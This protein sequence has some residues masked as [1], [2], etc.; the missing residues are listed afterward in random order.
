MSKRAVHS[1]LLMVVLV[2]VLSGS[3][4]GYYPLDDPALIGW[5]TCDEGEGSVVADSS[6]NGNDGTFVNGDPVWVEG[7]DGTAVELTIPTLIEIPVMD[8]TLEEATMAGWIKPYGTQP[9]WAS[10]MMHREGS[11]HGFNV[12][13]DYRLAYHWND[14]S[15]SWSYRGDAYVVDNEWTFA[16][17]TIEPDRATFYVNG[18]EASANVASHPAAT[19]DGNV[20]LGGD[21]TDGQSGRRMTGAL[22]D[23]SFFSRALTAEEIEAIMGG[24][25]DPALAALLSPENGATDVS[26]DVT[27]AWT[28]G[29]SAATHDV[30][31]GTSLEDVEAASRANPMDLLVSQGQTAAIYEA[32]RLDFG[33]TYYWR[34]DEVGS[35]GAVLAGSVW[36]FT[37]EPLSYP[38]RNVI[39]TTNGVSE[40]DAGPENTVNGSGLNAG[41]QHSTAT[42]DMWLAVSNGV[43]PL[44][45]QYEFDGVYKLHEMM[46]WNYNVMFEVMLGFG[47]KDVAVEYSENGTD[48]TALGDVQLAQATAQAAYAANTTIDFAGVAAKYVKLTVNSGYGMLGQ[49]GLSEV[50]FTY[51]PVQAREPQPA[52]GQIDVDPSG[53]L[54]WRAG[55]EAATHEVYLSTDEAAVA[56]GSA[57]VDTVANTDYALAGLDLQLG[58]TYYWKVDEVNEAEA[59]S[60]WEGRVWSF[61]T[62]ES[63]VVEDFESYG[64]DE[65]ERIY[66]TWIDGWVN[67]TGSTVGY[68][69]TPFAEQSI[70]NSGGQSMPLF[71]DNS[72]TTVSEAERTFIAPQNWARNGIKTLAVQFHGAQDNTGQLY[73]MINNTKIVYNSDASDINKAQWQP[74]LIDLSSVGANLQSVTKLV[75]GVE[76]SGA[77]GTIYIDDIRLYRKDI[78]VVTP[79]EPD[80][81]GLVLYYALDEG[82]G[83]TVA[84]S[85]GNGN[86]GV[87]DGSPA[88]I[89]GVSG[90]ALGF[91]G[92]RDYVTAGASLLN[93]LQAFSIACWLTGDLSLTDR[94][95]LIGQNDCIEY[96]ISASDNVQ[97]WSAG[98]GAV[99]LA[100]AYDGDADWHHIVA[101]GDGQTVT[102]Y[103]DGKPAISGGTAITDTYGSSTYPVNVGGG[104]IFDATGNWFSGQI[105]EIYIYQRALSAAE[106]AGLAGRT[107]PVVMPF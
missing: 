13:A 75:I 77:G 33:Q 27:L 2:A 62:Q 82:A 92:S 71:Y 64:D 24:L 38:V 58:S 59:I 98:S 3:A 46:V 66:E 97:I 69:E 14:D 96:G 30:Y 63:F 45:I 4:Y 26:R 61:S 22:D 28:A 60:A 21:G 83:A 5:W 99:D 87:I 74:W 101:V 7:V 6:V 103:L 40:A 9:D 78:E 93:D 105:D 95:G 44:A 107:E 56:D 80:T 11:A 12:L 1:I 48:W 34:I 106:V 54:S 85:S 10:L 55:R 23:V 91:D 49:F 31:I 39:A 15:A 57:V 88:W 53:T 79:V 20:Y 8:L 90:S 35:D 73:L 19:W 76:G 94:S 32:G 42:S 81:A 68:L 51:I 104:G 50:R 72:G 37:V 65:G 86:N 100:W 16:A 47:L 43:D 18:V 41:D 17:V 70:V 29:E 84:D 52:E 67:E 25:A 36:S 89:S 102:I